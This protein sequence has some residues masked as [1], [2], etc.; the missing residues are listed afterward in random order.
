[1]SVSDDAALI[2]DAGPGPNPGVYAPLGQP[3][4]VPR[5]ELVPD[6]TLEEDPLRGSVEDGEN[7]KGPAR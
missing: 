5:D 1:M 3:G 7:E 6:G 4:A 2:D